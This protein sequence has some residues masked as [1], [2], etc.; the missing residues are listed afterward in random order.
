[1]ED[2]SCIDMHT[3]SEDSD[4]TKSRRELANLAIACGIKGLCLTNHDT[5]GGQLEFLADARQVGLETI[6]GIEVS[7]VYKK[8]M[9]HIL[10]YGVDPLGSDI[11]ARYLQ[12]TW[13]ALNAGDVDL[14]RR[15][16]EVGIELPDEA[17]DIESITRLTGSI[18]E[19]V[20]ANLLFHW[21]QEQSG[22][23]MKA[24]WSKVFSNK[25]DFWK[26][27]IHE[28]MLSVEQAIQLV[29]EL[30]GKAVF[31]HPGELM[32]RYI[33]PPVG[34]EFFWDL[35]RLVENYGIDGIEAFYPKHTSELA[36]RLVLFA[37]NRKLFVTGGSDFHGAYTPEV[38]LGAPYGI[39]F[40]D[41]M[42]I[43]AACES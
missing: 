12:P 41:F 11:V 16:R 9:V 7:A 17:T 39:T 1:M 42:E 13:D 43:K 28:N 20:S 14:V 37:R 8:C 19:T 15:A 40:D 33:G 2:K 34:D 31:A 23:P 29:H 4:G 35:L 22:L 32:K 25:A 24:I 30:G 6:S 36:F 3:H 26:L 18:G 10:G 5:L 21:M 27:F 38:T